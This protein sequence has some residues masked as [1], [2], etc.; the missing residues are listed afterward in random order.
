VCSFG[1]RKDSIGSSYPDPTD[2]K[3]ARATLAAGEHLSR[4]TKRPEKEGLEGGVP[5][6]P[7]GCCQRSRGFVG[8]A[9]HRIS[10][11]IPQRESAPARG[12]GCLL[13]RGRR[14]PRGVVDTSVLLA[15]VAGFRNV[16]HN[17]SASLL[18]RWVSDNTFTWHLRAAANGVKRM[19]G[20]GKDMVPENPPMKSCWTGTQVRSSLL[21]LRS[22]HRNSARPL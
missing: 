13:G 22:T 7:E 20:E 14:R 18:K 2:Q 10:S 5:S 16:G 4:Y 6:D 19:R 9:D 17:A 12:R 21:R 3:G 8:K 15:G 1:T 11:L